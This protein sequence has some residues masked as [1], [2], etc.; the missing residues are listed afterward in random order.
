[1]LAG[2]NPPSPGWVADPGWQSLLEVVPL[3]NLGPAESREFLA[4]RGVPDGRQE[5]AVAFTHGHPFALALV[6]DA[7]REGSARSGPSRSPILYACCCPASS[8]RY[9]A[10]ATGPR[11]RPPP[12][13]G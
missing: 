13:C 6:A 7:L 10:R 2:R 1:M 9:P 8:T 11:W 5:A 12:T 3:R 4:A